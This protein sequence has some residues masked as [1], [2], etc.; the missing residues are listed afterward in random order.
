MKNLNEY[1]KIVNEIFA[2]Y[3]K[4]GT[5]DWDYNI[6][7]VDL[8]Y[9]IGSLSK[10]VLQMKNQRFNDG[11]SQDEIKEKIADELADIFTVTLFISSQLSV[12]LD[13]AFS[14]MVLSDQKKIKERSAN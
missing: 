3:S 10:R 8:Q 7:L 5:Q 4:Q 14:K 6:A 11:L 2:N 9:Q 13:E 12:N 1:T